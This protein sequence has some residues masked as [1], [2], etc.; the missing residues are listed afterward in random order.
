VTPRR[1]KTSGPRPPATVP[2]GSRVRTAHDGVRRTATASPRPAGRTAGAAR[3]GRPVAGC[4]GAAAAV[5]GGYARAKG[6]RP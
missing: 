5:P 6:V 4:S 2:R 3:P 1:P